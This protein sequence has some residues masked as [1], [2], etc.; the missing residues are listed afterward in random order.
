[1]EGA[2]LS[3]RF[4]TLSVRCVVLTLT[5][6]AA[7]IARPAAAA[8]LYVAAIDGRLLRYEITADG[9]P[10]L[11]LTAA[12]IDT[13]IG[14]AFSPTGELFATSAPENGGAVYRFTN[15]LA[16]VAP[17]GRIVDSHF[18]GPHWAAVRGGELFVAQRDG[19]AVVRFR[20]DG[21]GAPAF[22]GSLTA[23]LVPGRARGIAV[24][25]QGDELLVSECCGVDRISR[26]RFDAAGAPVPAGVLTGNGLRNP[27]DIAFSPWG[28][29]FVA[30]ADAN[31]VSRFLFEADG[32]VRPN[33]Q[34]TGGGMT[35]PL[36][37][38]FTP[39][40]ELLVVSVSRPQVYRWVFDGA[41]QARSNGTFTIAAPGRDLE[42][43]PGSSGVTVSAAGLR[44]QQVTCR[45]QTTQKAVT[46]AVTG[47]APWACAAA[48][49]VIGKGDTVQIELLG[50]AD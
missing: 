4:R 3:L 14:L 48:G 16:A 30:N 12:T 25:P 46:L 33:G 41:G 22:L 5:C 42:I 10:V 20:V 19:D 36:G 34:L 29:M 35:V 23:G 27:H 9:P 18:R 38:T 40:G 31:T 37:L 45:N 1:M 11:E 28:E 15:P 39:W 21:T 8:K 13:P 26:F 43:A 6:L 44:P 7:G 32:T 49:L 50:T 24:S 47:P 2:P 17:N